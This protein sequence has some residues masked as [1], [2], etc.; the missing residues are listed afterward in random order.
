MQVVYDKPETRRH[1]VFKHMTWDEQWVP[2]DE[3]GKHAIMRDRRAE[4]EQHDNH[5]F[6]GQVLYFLE[7]THTSTSV[8]DLTLAVCRPHAAERMMIG[9]PLGSGV[10]KSKALLRPNIRKGH[11]AFPVALKHIEDK[12]AMRPTV[13]IGVRVSGRQGTVLP[14][15]G[16]QKRKQRARVFGDVIESVASPD[17]DNHTVANHGR[18]ESGKTKQLRCARCYRED[19][20][21][22]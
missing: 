7:M 10:W 20:E 8:P 5:V 9:S 2:T 6:V 12:R 21:E 4:V 17:G 18:W 22:H 15:T 1:V 13:T 11:D 19:G 3:Y 14:L 16:N